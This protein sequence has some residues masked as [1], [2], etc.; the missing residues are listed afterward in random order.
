VP[1]KIS[2]LIYLLGIAQAEFPIF[3]EFK[4]LRWNSSERFFLQP[5]GSARRS[6]WQFLLIHSYPIASETYMCKKAVNK[7]NRCISYLS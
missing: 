7:E 3:E 4:Q 1:R 2:V 6:C 5:V